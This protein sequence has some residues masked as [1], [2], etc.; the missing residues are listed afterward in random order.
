VIGSEVAEKLFENV[1]AVG[2]SVR[3]MNRHFTVV[4]VAGSKGRVLGQSFDGFAL[5][6][7]SSFEAMYGR[8]QTTTVS[9]K[10]LPLFS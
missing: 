3:I 7:I 9:V 8:R 4:G 2:R 1:D 5:L 10:P 6:P